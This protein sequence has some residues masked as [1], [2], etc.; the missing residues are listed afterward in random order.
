MEKAAQ[1]DWQCYQCRGNAVDKI[2]GGRKNRSVLRDI[3]IYT[4]K[5]QEEIL[6]GGCLKYQENGGCPLNRSESAKGLADLSD[7]LYRGLLIGE[8]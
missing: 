7:R 1:I 6:W 5:E 8:L 2:V 4:N 3:A